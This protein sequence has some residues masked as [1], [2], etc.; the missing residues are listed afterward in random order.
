MLPK[1][2]VNQIYLWI[3]A[4]TDSSID[5]TQQLATDVDQRLSS[6][7]IKNNNKDVPS[8]HHIIDTISYWIGM[9]PTADFSN[10]FR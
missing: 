10:S 4:D 1:S 7:T 6:Y 5:A 3:N 8:S 9:A 2:N